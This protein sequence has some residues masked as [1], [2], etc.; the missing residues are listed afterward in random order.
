MQKRLAN[1]G[2]YPAV[3]SDENVFTQ[4]AQLRKFVVSN[5][6]MIARGNGRCYGDAS[7]GEHSISM[8]RYDKVLAFDKENGILEAQAGVTLDQILDIIVPHGWFL[9]VT[10][11]TKYITLGGAVASDVHG[12]NHHVDGSFSGHIIDMDIITGNGETICCSHTAHTDLFWATCGGMGL[13][14]V[15]TRIKFSLKKISTAYI[16]QTQIKA[17]NLEEVIRLF[18]EY[19]HYTYSMAWIDCLQKGDSFGRSILIVG[20]HAAPEELSAKQKEAPLKLPAKRKLS[21]PFNLPSFVLNTFTVKAFNWLYYGKNYKKEMH[22]V[23]PYEPFFYPLDAILHWNRGYGKAG[24]VQ[25]QFVLPLNKK[26]GLVTILKRISDKG[27]GS[28]LAVLKVF[29]QQDSLISFPMEGYTLAL[30]FPVRNGLLPFLDELDEIVLQY[31]GRLYLS[32]DARMKQEIFW[33]SYP[34]AAKFAAIVQQYNT[35]NRFVS[36]QSE[37]LLLTK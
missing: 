6:H 14:G 25:Y 37:R 16:K 8:L 22:K 13:T 30:D 1:W 17:S 18:D 31:G 29:G 23:I 24:F 5:T 10:P 9:P 36:L 7:L 19:K 12:K 20:E 21:V 2:N 26:E 15:I 35:N 33:N 4:E 27:W 32:K 34:N 3:A 28:F 11:G